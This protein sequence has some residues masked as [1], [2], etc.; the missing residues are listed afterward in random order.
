MT[1][2]RLG[3]TL[4]ELLIVIA[5]VVSLAT[6]TI[7]FGIGYVRERALVLTTT[8][9]MQ[10]VLTGLAQYTTSGDLP[11]RLQRVVGFD[12]QFLTLGKAV[13]LLSDTYGLDLTTATR[14]THPLPAVG[15]AYAY[16]ANGKLPP[17][18]GCRW[19]NLI[20]WVNS[21]GQLNDGPG[22]TA[23]SA[24]DSRRFPE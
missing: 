10:Q 5:I 4:V 2:S 14:G 11:E 17:G 3:F 15:T 24:V 21:S 8:H 9:R 23:L 7:V 12:R 22:A 18:I 13:S 19:E 16:P 1:R 6:I 20:A